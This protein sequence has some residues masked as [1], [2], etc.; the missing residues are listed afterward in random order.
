MADHLHPK[1]PMGRRTTM[2]QTPSGEGAVTAAELAQSDELDREAIAQAAQTGETVADRL[3]T[4]R[5]R[6]FQCQACFINVGP[7]YLQGTIWY[8]KAQC[9]MICG[10]CADWR[11][12]TNVIPLATRSEVHDLSLGDLTR[13]VKSRIPPKESIP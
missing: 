2:D 11:Q 9:L 12:P 5:I 7:G 3:K 13:L 4:R 1:R 6:K 10:G 8:D